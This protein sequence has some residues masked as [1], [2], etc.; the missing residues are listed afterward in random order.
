[1]PEG[2]EEGQP[3]GTLEGS[4]EGAGEAAVVAVNEL[5]VDQ[6]GSHLVPV[7]IGGEVQKVSVAEAVAGYQRQADYTQKTQ[8]HASDVQFAN[9]I[10]EAL[11]T[12]PQGTLELLAKANGV[13]LGAAQKAAEAPAWDAY[14]EPTVDPRLSQLDSRLAVFE[15]A[16]ASQRLNAEIARLGSKYGDDFNPQE[17]VA[18]AIAANATDLEGVYK[19]IAFDRVYATSQ[20]TAQAAAQLA[21]TQRAASDAA[22]V[23]GGASANGGRGEPEPEILTIRD[24]WN[25]AK[26]E[27]GG[28]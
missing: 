15:E 6:F 25:A 5:D 10:R 19:S 14:D 1:M 26:R 7:K 2:V 24:A 18:A 17:V 23:A 27:H 28:G 22:F 11:K 4:T 12:D 8:A 3:T 21:A 20:Q 16:Q 9:A 13:Q